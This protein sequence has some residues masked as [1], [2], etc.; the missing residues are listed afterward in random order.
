M[1]RY[2][3][4]G[5]SLH[6]F[7][8]LLF[9]AEMVSTSA[10]ARWSLPSSPLGILN[11]RKWFKGIIFSHWPAC[12]APSPHTAQAT[13]DSV[14]VGQHPAVVEAPR[15]ST[16]VAEAE[17]PAS[18]YS[19]EAPHNGASS[20]VPPDSQITG[21]TIEQA[22]RTASAGIEPQNG[23]VDTST[24]AAT[25]QTSK[26]AQPFPSLDESLPV[27]KAVPGSHPSAVHSNKQIE[28]DAADLAGMSEGFSPDLI[29]ASPTTQVALSCAQ[30]LGVPLH[31]F[32][33]MPYTR[34]QYLPH[35]LS[36]AA[37]PGPDGSKSTRYGG[38]F[39][40][41]KF[42]GQARVSMALGL[43]EAVSAMTLIDRP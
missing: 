16:H 2:S 39:F 20:E 24:T 7:D 11:V 35:P 19:T 43:V 5:P 10:S 13:S 34:T 15:W 37:L 42:V 38:P 29:V 21:R 8:R 23:S 17:A 3:K 40:L 36:G 4:P 9:V 28:L 14:T 1:C 31:I 32:Y 33:L 22:G 27:A 30:R 18:A 25:A 41:G 12:T 26:S 6:Y